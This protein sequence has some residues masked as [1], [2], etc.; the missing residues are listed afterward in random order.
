M[1]PFILGGGRRGFAPG[2][3]DEIRD[4]KHS[5]SPFSECSFV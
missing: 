2:Q 1:I 4:S 3:G 5:P